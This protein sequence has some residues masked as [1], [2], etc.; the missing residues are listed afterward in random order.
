[1]TRSRVAAM[2]PAEPELKAFAQDVGRNAP[3]KL[4][5]TV[6]VQ[7]SACLRRLRLDRRAENRVASVIG[8][9]SQLSA[10]C[11]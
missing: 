9:S 7:I 8:R 1:M 5:P 11:T 10:P 6:V 2:S 4:P 3:S